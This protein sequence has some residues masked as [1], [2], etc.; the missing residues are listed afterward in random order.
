MVKTVIIVEC[1]MVQEV[2]STLPASEHEIELLDMDIG[3]AGLPGELDELEA[4]ISDL[5]G[6]SAYHAVL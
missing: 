1:G 6:S 2:F 4:R 3:N 5:Y